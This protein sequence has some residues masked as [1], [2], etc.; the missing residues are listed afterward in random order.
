MVVLPGCALQPRTVKL[1]LESSSVMTIYSPDMSHRSVGAVVFF[2]LG[3]Q[4][5]FSQALVVNGVADRSDNNINSASFSVPV[6]PGHSYLVLLD[7]KPVPAGVTNR[8]VGPDYHEIL[9]WRTNATTGAVTNRLVRFVIM[10]DRGDPE[11]GLIAWTPYPQTPSANEE[12]TGA[13][14]HLMAPSQYPAALP[15][16]VIARVQNPSGHARR[17]NGMV[18]SP[19]QPA[20]RILRG[21]GSG[22]FSAAAPGTSIEYNAQLGSIGAYKEVEIDVSTSWTSVAGTLS[23]NVVWP[24]NSRIHITGNVTLPAGSTLTI[25]A[26]TVVRINPLINITNSGA[27]VINGT[28]DQPVVFTSTNTAV[29]P[30]VRTHAWGGFFLRGASAALVANGTIFVGGGGAAS[31]SFSPGDSHRSEQA[32]FLAHS[33]ARLYLTNCA[34]I[35][36]AG[37]IAN[38]YNSDVT[39]DH[40]L[41]QRAITTGE[42]VAGTIIVNHSA[43]IEF[44]ED[45]GQ[46]NS[47]L[48]SADYDGIYFTTGTHLIYNS[49]I[50]FLKDDAIDSGSGGAGTVLVTNCWIESALHEANAWSGEGRVATEF[51]TVLMNSGQGFECGWST[52]N[53]SPLTYA[54]NILSIGNSVGARFGD[55]YPS[56][57]P[58][59]GLLRLTNSFVL[60]NYRDVWGMT[61]RTDN[62]GW[63]YRSNQMDIRSNFLSQPNP[64][65]PTNAIWD[66]AQDGWRLARFMTTPPNAPVGI[67][68]ATWTNT[69]AVSTIFEGVP[70]RL[71]S[72]TTNTVSVDYVFQ[73]GA[74]PPVS[75]TLSFQPGEM[76]KRIFPYGFNV[77]AY[78]NPRVI[79]VNPV[80]GELT[81]STNVQFQGTA[82]AGLPITIYAN[83]VQLDHARIR[84]GYPLGLSAP[85]G[86]PATIGYAYEWT[87]GI[88]RTGLITFAPGQTLAWAAP[89]EGDLSGI[90][91]V[92]FNLT[93]GAFV[94]PV[95]A[96]YV[97]SSSN[98]TPPPTTIIARGAAWRYPNVAGALPANWNT[99]AY[100]DAAWQSG[101][102]EL[103]FGDNDEARQITQ[104]ASQITYYFRRTITVPDPSAFANLSLWMRRDDGAVMYFNGQEVHRSSS[105]PPLPAVIGF[106]TEANNEGENAEQTATLNAT[107]LV[108]GDNLVAVEVHQDDPGSSD[109]SFNM[110]LLGNAVA[111]PSAQK[112]YVGEF[113]GQLIFA[114]SDPTFIL[115]QADALTGPW[116][117]A[118]T[119]SPFII[120]PDPLVAHRFFRLKR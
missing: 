50:G 95:Q 53:N 41:I 68:F 61:W 114:W 8:V 109:I 90:D 31:I 12:F 83:G 64:F 115:E 30:H 69:F 92:Q 81:G 44:P 119:A 60:H 77:A 15:V 101:P 118:D 98:P 107:A 87:G 97:K 6:D 78:P 66:G 99:T 22:F 14:L 80:G 103:G 16:P 72:F 10:S 117:T 54:G 91:I 18:T 59:N 57:G 5:G 2:A 110:E 19:S 38:G 76:L 105:M 104:F 112:V 111:P 35:N 100:S 108:P 71:S 85:L 63:F 25:G 79:L 32:V 84:E 9:V 7:G 37:Q 29:L 26:G 49:L 13:A 46:V 34:V 116:T 96:Y 70:V 113:D 39:Y 11:R 93:S 65:H 88:L 82:T 106:T 40:C 24:N 43:L 62:T 17:V 21:H 75:G 86:L 33:G 56:I 23:G 28:V 74:L 48:A 27:T 55:N 58:F 94:A 89:P 42:Y 47:S 120:T 67:G 1:Q 102:S 45:N 36:T 4:F 51:D 73:A 20:F 3:I 52:G